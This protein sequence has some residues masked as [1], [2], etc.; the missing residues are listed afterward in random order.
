MKHQLSIAF[1]LCSITIINHAMEIE[2]S[3]SSHQQ[4]RDPLIIQ[5]FKHLREDLKKSNEIR[6]QNQ[7][8]TKKIITNRN[9]QTD[10]I[11]YRKERTNYVEPPKP[12]YI[13]GSRIIDEEILFDGKKERIKAFLN[14][15]F[16]VHQEEKDLAY[17]EWWERIPFD[18]MILLYCAAIK[19]QTIFSNLPHDVIK[20]IALSMAYA[21]ESL[22]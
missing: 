19:D 13:Y 17:L 5:K 8:N 2:L 11:T 14:I 21:T 1:I 22:L 16:K 15:G 9:Q 4:S 7:L 18:N 10:I 12:D 20:S 6:R 3:C